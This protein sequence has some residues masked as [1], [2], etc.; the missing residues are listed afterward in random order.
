MSEPISRR[1]AL[2]LLAGVGAVALAGGAGCFKPVPTR[3]TDLGLSSLGRQLSLTNATVIDVTRGAALPGK[4]ILV[5]DGL[6]QGVYDAGAPELAQAQPVD[7]H[8]TYMI[9]GLINAHCHLNLPSTMTVGS[10]E[11]G[12]AQEQIFRNY[13]DA[14]GWGITTA[15]DMGALPKIIARDREAINHGSLPGPR[16]LT[17]MSVITVPNGYPDFI[18]DVNWLVKAMI[19]EPNLRVKNAAEAR[20]AV[21]NVRDHG[22]DLVKIAFDHRSFLYGR[23]RL[24]VLTDAEV[25]AIRNE[26]DKCGLP[27][28]AHHL[29][30][31]GLD[32]GLQFGVHSLEHVVTDVPLTD[33][34]VRMILDA[35]MRFV[36]TILVGISL[37]FKSTGDPFNDDPLINEVLRWREEVQLAELPRHCTPAIREKSKSLKHYYE[38]EEYALKKNRSVVSINPKEATRLLVVAAKNLKRLIAEGAILGAGN[39]S[40]VPFDFPGMLHLEL[41]MLARQGMTNAQALRAATLVNA[42][43]CGL[44]DKCGSIAAGRWADLVL[45]KANPLEDI[46]NTA[47]VQAVFKHGRLV[48]KADDFKVPT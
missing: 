5:G 21:K 6:I 41:E 25:E 16:I 28:A 35:K 31:M 3:P 39:D 17:A 43:I 26:A 13:E 14:I 40:G 29:Y 45:L 33:A 44:K 20:D 27:V 46:R 42:E 30:S 15:R 22:A 4:A 37:A 1:Q 8:G 11:L 32:R 7:C 9:P 38:A 12:M 2:S 19:G 48:S 24:D 36:P 47:G 18:V 10:G 34:Q 23:G